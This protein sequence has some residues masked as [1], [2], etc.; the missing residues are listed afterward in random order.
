MIFK[1]LKCHHPLC[2]QAYENVHININITLQHNTFLFFVMHGIK[3]KSVDGSKK[4]FHC[5]D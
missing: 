4:L 2:L 1:N 5:F 3:L